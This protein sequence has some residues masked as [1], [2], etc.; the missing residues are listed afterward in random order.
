MTTARAT[1]L[2]AGGG[3]FEVTSG[4]LTRNGVID[5]PSSLTK[6]GN[7]ALELNAVN[8]YAGGTRV[9]A[10][11]LIANVNGALGSGAVGVDGGATLRLNGGFD[12]GVRQV[13]NRSGYINLYGAGTLG[14]ARVT[15]LGGF[16]YLLGSSTAANATIV[17]NGGTMSFQE[18]AVLAV[19]SQV[20]TR[21]GSYT[22]FLGL[23]YPRQRLAGG[24]RGWLGRFLGHV[25]SGLQSPDHRWR[26]RGG[27]GASSWPERL[28]R[29]RQQPL[30]HRERHDRGTA[31]PAA[32]PV[33]GWSRSAPAR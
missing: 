8:A 10:G 16:T 4:T 18:E 5:G 19:N 21:S 13:V 15:N 20:T 26:H 2:G 31:V 22:E 28:D 23:E 29:G 17:N 1:T 14:N 24:G 33:A 12:L 7:A 32:A 25:R 3:T 11:M 30:H 6:T 27:R 9:N